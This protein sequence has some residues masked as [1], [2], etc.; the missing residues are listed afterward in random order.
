[1]KRKLDIFEQDTLEEKED[2][3]VLEF[4]GRRMVTDKVVEKPKEYVIP[5]N[6]TVNEDMEARE[7]IIEQSKK[8][9]LQGRGGQSDYQ[10][11]KQDL[12]NLPQESDDAY[13][14]IPVEHFGVALLKG[15]GWKEGKPVGKNP[16]GLV[17][18][19]K[20]ESRPHLLGLGAKPLEA[21]KVE[22]EP[23]IQE[24][25]EEEHD[26]VVGDGVVIIAGKHS[27]KRGRIT[28][29]DKRSSGTV[30]LV[31][32]ARVWIE[33][34]EHLRTQLWMR[35]HL[36]VKMV[37]KRLGDG[38]YYGRK[39]LIQDISQHGHGVKERDLETRIPKV[40]RYGMVVMHSEKSFVG[41]HC[42]IM[43]IDDRTETCIARLENNFEIV[44]LKFD[45]VCEFEEV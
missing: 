3:K 23:V 2:E 21:P 25:V 12:L 43:E 11:Y 30:V 22:E 18:P 41:Q 40:G 7:L 44:P 45:Q 26:F 5:V 31:D 13:D 17:E 28:S 16:N 29:I 35:P 33:D 39:C 34:L 15:M 38:R 20:L 4:R 1:M 36:I 9:L 37:S 42:K 27:K 10:V 14:R 6:E 24:E 32:K 19:I 8:P